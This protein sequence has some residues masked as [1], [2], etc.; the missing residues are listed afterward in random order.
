MILV[1]HQIKEAVKSNVIGIEEFSLDCVQPAS[2]DLRIGHKLYTSTTDSPDK[3]INLSENGGFFL[4]PPY[5]NALL[6]TH[7]ILRLSK[8]HIGRFG[9]TSGFARRGIFAS[10][11]P[12]VDPGYEG[13][14]FVSIFNLLPVSRVLTFKE[15]F[16]TIEFHSLDEEPEH[17]YEGPYQS[18]LD[19]TPEIL[20]E[21]TKLEGLNLNQVQSQFSE[22]SDSV[23]KWSKYLDRLDDFI[24]AFK[25]QTEMME[26]LTLLY[27]DK[28]EKQEIKPIKTRN[29][30]LDDATE[31]IYK[32]F[33]KDKHLF[34]SDIS[35]QLELDYP[36][37][38]EACEKLV[39]DGLIEGVSD[40]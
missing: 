7:E 17:S 37:V 38:V 10:V 2:Y 28:E 12:Q 8:K 6:M 27:G 30:S 35:E 24:S 40:E 4:L 22:L 36:L 39:R 19:I 26:K 9:L 13:R 3:A 33:Q 11:G 14:L 34:Y 29:I 5:G 31:E 16:L 23:K 25:L 15:K 18:K 21:M 32:L 20:E 1:D